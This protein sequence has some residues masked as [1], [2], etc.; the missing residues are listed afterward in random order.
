MC[1]ENPAQLSAQHVTPRTFNGTYPGLVEEVVL[2]LIH[3]KLFS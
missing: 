2:G 3:R 1:R